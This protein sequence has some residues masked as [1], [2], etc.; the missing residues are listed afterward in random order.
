M[1]RLLESIEFQIETATVNSICLM[2]KM[3]KVI[4]QVNL[5]MIVEELHR[6]RHS[7]I[8]TDTQFTFCYEALLAAVQ[9]LTAG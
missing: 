7:L 4:L 3:M 6:Q 9:S 2:M 1:E 5:P 8:Q